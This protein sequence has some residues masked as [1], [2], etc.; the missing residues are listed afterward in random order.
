MSRS[1][2]GWLTG[3]FLY[4]VAEAI[5][6]KTVAA[7]TGSTESAR[8]APKPPAPPYIQY[9]NPPVTC[10]GRTVDAAD[11]DGWHVRFK[12]F[13]YG[14]V[15]VALTR[16][17]PSTWDGMVTEGLA[18]HDHAGLAASAERACRAFLAR[19]DAALG[20][21]RAVLL[22]EDYLVFCATRIEG[23]ES[24]DALLRAHGA[25][26]AQLLRGE[27]DPLSAQ[28]REE[29]LRH[30]ISYLATD[31][32]I[33][34]WNAAFIA[35]TEAGARGVLEILEFANSQ[36]LE[37]RYYDGLLDGE[38]ARIYAQL[39]R[40]GWGQNWFDRRFTRAARQVHSL[41][42][43]VNELTDKTE[44]ALKVAGDVY[45]ARLFNL[46][47]ARLG[48]DHWKGTVREKL[49]TLDDIYRFAVEQTAM[50]RGEI[51]ELS[52]VLILLFELGL[53]FAGIMQ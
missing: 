41:F 46:T 11:V 17:L 10:E 14:V 18:W 30:R 3:F 28:E 35:D 44:N 8:M 45:A 40:P 33:P 47:G 37:F 39:E 1:V 31:V 51:L 36:L 23:I 21:P 53:F 19:V 15:S 6:L 12:A 48:L 27:R 50:T 32:V 49:K 7:L 16:P 29:V 2:S 9:A 43:E 13:D 20:K 34:T 52:I 25:D 26:L 24:G 42:I 22:S 5:D 4:D 38:L